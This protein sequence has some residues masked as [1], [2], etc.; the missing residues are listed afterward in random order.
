MIQQINHAERQQSLHSTDVAAI[1]QL[2]GARDA[3]EV[4]LEK[5]GKIEP[6]AG[7][8]ATEAGQYIE[9]SVLDFAESVLGTIER[10][11][12]RRARGLDFPLAATLDGQVV[13]TG[14]PVE[15]KT[16]GLVGPVYGEWGD[17]LS[18]HVPA[19][20]LVQATVQMICTDQDLCH[21]FALIG[22]RGFVQYEI[23]RDEEVAKTII[24]RCGQW[25]RRH[26]E[27]GVECTGSEPLP[28]SVL[29]RIKRE[30]ASEVW[31]GED[32]LAAVANWETAK[33]TRNAAEKQAELMQAHVLALLGEAEAGI[34]PD[35]RA[36]TYMPTNRKGYTVDP[37]TYRTL[38]LRKA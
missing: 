22:G 25:W 18:D 14:K 15:A 32:A 5:Q 19:L 7:N 9:P 1:L 36:V 34:L 6:W 27:Q 33:A 28:L 29:K 4:Q 21:L 31:L 20:Y 13:T 2:E 35:G 30:P 3:R 23:R 38:R 11:V 26:I 10:N 37:T 12:R 8:N 24:E 16:T 17:S